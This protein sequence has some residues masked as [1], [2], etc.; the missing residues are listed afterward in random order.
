MGIIRQTID[1]DDIK[2]Y[3]L[4]TI[5]CQIKKYRLLYFLCQIR[6]NEN[7]KVWHSPL[8]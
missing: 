3:V 7:M 1:K 6:F 8:L 5:L 2:K 4:K